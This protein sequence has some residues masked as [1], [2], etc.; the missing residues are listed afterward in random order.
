M[1]NAKTYGVGGSA[2]RGLSKSPGFVVVSL[3]IVVGQFLIVQ[4]GGEVFRTEPITLRDWLLIIAGT[5]VVLWIGEIT[6]AISGRVSR[7]V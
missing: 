2:F 5:S 3:L 1:F 6:R 7:S 4:F